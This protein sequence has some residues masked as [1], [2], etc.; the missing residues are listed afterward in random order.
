MAELNFRDQPVR[1]GQQSALPV[2]IADGGDVSAL[3]SRVGDTEAAVL[4]LEAA[5]LALQAATD[6]SALGDY[7]DDTAASVGGVL[8]GEIYR[9]GSIVKVRVS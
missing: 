7:A 6:W 3:D 2:V 8:V 4:A 5:V 9:T 1:R